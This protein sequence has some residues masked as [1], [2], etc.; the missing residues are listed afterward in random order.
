LDPS[1]K[2]VTRLVNGLMG[3]EEESEPV[4]PKKKKKPAPKK[5]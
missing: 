4:K 5:N 2:D 3:K 1:N